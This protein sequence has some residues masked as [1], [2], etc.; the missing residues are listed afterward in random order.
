MLN[1][2]SERQHRIQ[3][4]TKYLQINS[5]FKEKIITLLAGTLL[6]WNGS[7]VGENANQVLRPEQ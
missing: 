4:S 7:S 6:K 1:R 3:V 2:M 5:P